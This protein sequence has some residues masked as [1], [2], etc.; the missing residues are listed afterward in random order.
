MKMRYLRDKKGKIDKRYMIAEDGS[1]IR[2]KKIGDKL[3][4]NI[5]VDSDGYRVVT[6]TINGEYYN[7]IKIC[8]LQWLAWKGIIPKRFVIHHKD[9]NKENDHIDNLN[10]MSKS[11]HRKYHTT[12]EKNPNYGK[13]MFGENNPMWGKHHTEESNQKNSKSHI[14][15]QAGEKNPM[16]GIRKFGEDN[17]NVKIT[18]DQVEEIRILGYIDHLSQSNIAKK[19]GTTESNV[20]QILQGYRRNPNNL[21][22]PQLIL[23]TERR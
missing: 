17:P 19:V 5:Y 3:E 4:K 9:E 13:D 8:Q 1:Y 21:T 22:K 20:N 18:D 11:E 14:G 2:D 23:Q 12:G 15:L 7:Q 6:I 16:F 10:C